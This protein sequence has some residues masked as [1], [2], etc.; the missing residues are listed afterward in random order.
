MVRTCGDTIQVSTS[1]V[2]GAATGAIRLGGGADTIQVFDTVAVVSGGGDAT[3]R[4]DKVEF[5]LDPAVD[6][7]ALEQAVILIAAVTFLLQQ[8][9]AP[10]PL[11]GGV[12]FWLLSR[13]GR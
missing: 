6:R 4:V 9:H 13:V 2:V 1:A 10:D 8:V 7:E 11:L 3:V 5:P 12:V